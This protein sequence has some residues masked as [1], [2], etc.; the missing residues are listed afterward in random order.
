MDLDLSFVRSHFPGLNAEQVFFDNAGG[1]MTLKGVV[2]RI[3]EYLLTSDVQLGA[4]Y[5]TSVLA[6]ARY[7]EAR[8]RL[9][10]FIG[11]SRSEEVVFGPSSTILLSLL[12]QAI[13][14]EIKAGDVIIVTRV[15]HQANITPW[16]RLAKR[17]DATI[18][19]WEVDPVTR[20]LKL[21]DL[22]IDDRT[23]FVAMTHAS[24]ILGG[25][26]PIQ[27]VARIVHEFGAQ[28]CVDGVAYAP[29]RPLDLAAWDVDYYVFSLYKVYGPHHAILYGKYNRLQSLETLGHYF[30]PEDQVVG[31]LEPGNANYELSYGAAGVV[32]YFE[33]L[34]QHADASLTGAAA[35][36]M[37]W[38]QISAHEEVLA[39]RLLAFLRERSDV[40]IIGSEDS[41]AAVRVP[42]IS[43]VHES[44]LSSAIV[45][46]V[47]PHGLGIRFG[48][49]YA[50]QLIDVLN[51]N[52]SDGVVRVS[53]VH[54]NTIEEV[55]RLI[56][57]LQSVLS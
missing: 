13:E 14:P 35:R 42:T 27:E 43:F 18:R 55:D 4:S 15:D 38:D 26:E 6:G 24:N 37:A 44:L 34:G 17:C 3:A 54:Y 21:A 53:M 56:E 16:E 2:D 5:P 48:H 46:R 19:Y 51:L 50:A 12:A 8:T 29:H 39:E 22:P 31:K 41:S 47:D 32:D 30:F 9:S 20:E 33:E 57:L 23:R 36:K 1:S 7:D 25:I 52:S 28:L 11:A 10:E 45:N 40:T 49:F